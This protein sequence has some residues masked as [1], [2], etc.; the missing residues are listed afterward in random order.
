MLVLHLHRAE[1]GFL[2]SGQDQAFTWKAWDLAPDLLQAVVQPQLIL[3]SFLCLSFP[4]CAWQQRLQVPAFSQSATGLMNDCASS[5]LKDGH[6][7]AQ[8]GLYCLQPLSLSIAT[9]VLIVGRG[10][11]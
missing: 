7:A 2:S 3:A 9:D 4:L 6:W 10:A 8:S 5:S 11:L 1:P